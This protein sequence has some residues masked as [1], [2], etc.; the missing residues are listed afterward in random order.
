MSNLFQLIKGVDSTQIR[1]EVVH[2]DEKGA[3]DSSNEANTSLDDTIVENLIPLQNRT[4]MEPLGTNSTPG[5][6]AVDGPDAEEGGSQASGSRQPSPNVDIER[7]VNEATR[8]AAI[9]ATAVDPEED[10]RVLRQQI[11][12]ILATT[13]T[14]AIQV[15]RSVEEDPPSPVAR[16]STPPCTRR[17][18]RHLLFTI[19]TFVVMVAII[20]SLTTTRPWEKPVTDTLSSSGDT[21]WIQATP[22]GPGEWIQ[23]GPNIDG[24]AAED[25]SGWAVAMSGDASTVASAAYLNDGE[26][27]VDSGHVRVYRWEGGDWRQLGGDI[28]GAAAGD[29]FGRSVALSDDGSTVVIGSRLHG[30]NS[31][32]VRVFKYD[33]T[34]DT[35]PQVGQALN[36]EDN[37]DFAGHSVAISGDG[38]IVAFGV[39]YNS[40]SGQDAG[41]VKVFHL[42]GT[43]WS[44]M[45]ENI[46]GDVEG[47]ELGRAVSLSSDGH[48]LAMGAPYDFEDVVTDPPGSVRIL[49]FNGQEWLAR[50]WASYDQPNFH[51]KEADDGFGNAVSL[52]SNGRVVA[53]GAPF[54]KG[55]GY[56]QIHAFDGAVWVPL[57]EAVEGEHPQDQFGRFLS[58]SSDGLTLAVG[59][60]R[61]NGT[62]GFLSGNTR[63]FWFNGT[64]WNQLGQ[65]IDGA[66]EDDR[67]GW[68]VSISADGNSFIAG[69]RFNDGVGNNAGHARV[70]DFV[71]HNS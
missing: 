7:Q 43:V 44:Q 32:Q 14:P 50:G 31:G 5:A 42:N 54:P 4:G 63:V 40:D 41:Q 8:S 11:L 57:G 52:S 15:V 21:N 28:D 36:G 2:S 27:G 17:R 68:S 71:P 48:T 35:W 29:R 26:N 38:S 34:G 67:A 69:S 20:V 37:F 19:L 24:E 51:G 58:L 23:R 16:P 61:N 65:D 47:G 55:T 64:A 45:G 6:V 66:A 25:R 12:E 46:D 56:V 10:R 39:I 60:Y 33:E 30:I 59:A 1:D 62:A 49:T 9:E 53:I 70:F 3:H 18:K 13:A 22:R